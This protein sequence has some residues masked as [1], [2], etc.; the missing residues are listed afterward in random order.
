MKKNISIL[1]LIIFLVMV[2]FLPACMKDDMRPVT[3]FNLS[4]NGVL[5]SCEGNFMYGNASLSYY[6]KKDKTIENS[7][8]LRANGIPL[9]DVAQSI[10]I[11]NN[12][13]WIV[14]NNSGKIIAI[15]PN[16]FK[17]KGQITGLVSPRYIIFLNPYKAYVSDMYSKSIT[18]INPSSFEIMGEIS[19]DDKTGEYYRHSSEQFVIINNILYTN[20]WSFDDKILV[21]DTEKDS[22][23]QKI[24][25]LKQPRKIVADK[26]KNIWVLCDG[27]YEG[28]NY[29]GDAGIIKININ[30]N[31]I[32]KKFLLPRH[33]Y[34]SDLKI[35]SG[36]DTVYF[37]NKDVFRFEITQEP[38]LKNPII[39]AE[40]KNFY[41]LGIDP[42]NSDIYVSDAIDYLQSGVVYRFSAQLQSLDTFRTGIIPGH[43]AFK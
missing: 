17:I 1:F 38:D 28:S 31:S 19:I 4:D 12:L 6:N 26:N 13:A 42:Y 7:V 39:K 16:N 15:D 35:T 9:G 34:P 8:F 21:I 24:Q 11:Y 41:S 40:N 3:D 30:Q 23:I 2:I 10:F 14:V 25:V 29:Y 5:I 18:I 27:G 36:G 32:E 33:S 20:S 22:I 37:I 43:F